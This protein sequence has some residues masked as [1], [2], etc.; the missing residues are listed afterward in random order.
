MA[1]KAFR[2]RL[3]L[4]QLDDQSRIGV[5]P[6]SSGRQS[7]IVAIT[8]P[9]QFPQAAWDE[10]VRQGKLKRTGQGLYELAQP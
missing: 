3:K 2:K 8:P 1:L 4:T 7:G 6:M 10:L 5:G 9:D